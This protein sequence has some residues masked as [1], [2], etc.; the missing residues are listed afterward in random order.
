VVIGLDSKVVVT[1]ETH[2]HLGDHCRLGSPLWLLGGLPDLLSLFAS[3][4]GLE[5]VNLVEF[6]GPL[7]L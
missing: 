5:Q 6:L 2:F 4:A 7:I 3:I 1:A